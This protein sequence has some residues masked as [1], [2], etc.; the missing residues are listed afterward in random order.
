MG[1]VGLLDRLTFKSEAD[2]EI[3]PALF[4][5]SESESEY[6]SEPLEPDPKPK[7]SRKTPSGVTAPK[8]TIAVKKQCRD[9]LDD[10]F[11]LPVMLWKRRDPTCAEKAEEQQDEI[12]DALL[13]IIIKRP[14][15][16]AALTDL[17]SS[18][19]MIKMFKALYPLLLVIFAHHVAK[20]VGGEELADDLSDYAAPRL[21]G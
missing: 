3:D 18:G 14:A 5:E 15:W 8:V 2:S 16:V 21:A 17:G 11:G 12:V 7:R 10:L 20:T 4:S 13:A 19:D 1:S 6:D 9:T